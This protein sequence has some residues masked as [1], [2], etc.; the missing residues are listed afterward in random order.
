MDDGDDGRTTG[1]ERVLPREPASIR[2]VLQGSV[3]LGL[4]VGLNALGGLVFWLIAARQEDLGSIG[5]ASALF[6]AV[7]FANYV[8]SLGLPVALARFAGEDPASSVLSVWAMWLRGAAAVF[9]SAMFLGFAISSDVTD[10]LWAESPLL[11]AATYTVLAVG[12]ALAT[13]VEIRLVT[14]RL[15]GWVVLRAAIP[16]AMRIPLLLALPPAGDAA[17]RALWLFVLAAG[18]VAA[19][20]IVGALA[21]RLTHD[22]VPGVIPRPPDDHR[23]VARY[24]G[25]NWLGLVATEGPIF[26]VPFIVALSVESTEN[27]AFYVAWSFGAIAFV[28][29]Q[30]VAQVVLSEASQAGSAFVKMLGGLKLAL[31][32]TMIASVM[33]QLGAGTLA[34][35]YGD[36]YELIGDQLPLLVAASIGW[37]YSSMGLA[38]AR[39]RERHPDIVAISVVFVITTMGPTLIFT[40]EHGSAAATWSWLFGNCCTAALTGLLYLRWRD[41]ADHRARPT[42]VEGST[43]AGKVAP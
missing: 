19:S 5:Q 41:D 42:A 39:I 28:L 25:V 3:A 38:A 23:R 24:A 8:A 4:S 29:P 20:G 9:S 12:M 32:I 31:T 34:R 26:A 30:M 1:P 13:L 2:Q 35:I 37:S 22:R 21:L 14:L 36:G 40:G 33:S 7:L 15:W 16:A 27:A 43:I 10:P 17:H 6:Q 18:P 11:G